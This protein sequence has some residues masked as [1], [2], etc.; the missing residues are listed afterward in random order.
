MRFLHLFICGLIGAS[1]VLA[2]AKDTKAKTVTIPPLS[3]SVVSA[4]AKEKDVEKGLKAVL[5]DQSTDLF[6][7]LVGGVEK[8]MTT[9][10]DAE[11]LGAIQSKVATIQSLYTL[12]MQFSEGN[13]T[14]A[15][16]TIADS[17]IGSLN[18]PAATAVWETVKATRESYIAVAATKAALNI[19]TLYSVVN[20]DRMIVGESSGGAPPTINVDS[21]TVDYFFNKYLITNSSVRGM[22]R[23]YV[24]KV[25]HQDWPE[26]SWSNYMSG[27]M[28]IGSGIDTDEE[29]DLRQL[30]G[31]FKNVARGWIRSLLND[32]NKQVLLE[33]QKTRLRQEM[34]EY[35]KYATKIANYN[36][37]NFPAT[38]K[39]LL[40]IKNA[41][42]NISVYNN[43]LNEASKNN[44]NALSALSKASKPRA[45]KIAFETWK[46]VLYQQ[47]IT[48]DNYAGDAFYLR[49]EKLHKNLKSAEA[50]TLSVMKKL[51]DSM[52]GFYDGRAHV[53]EEDMQELKEQNR[54]E[55]VTEYDRMLKGDYIVSKYMRPLIIPPS[56]FTS[57]MKGGDSVLNEIVSLLNKG[58]YSAAYKMQYEKLG[59]S[60][61]GHFYS[62]VY[63]DDALAAKIKSQRAGHEAKGNFYNLSE[64]EHVS[65]KNIWKPLYEE[66]KASMEDLMECDSKPIALKGAPNLES[67]AGEDAQLGY[68]KAMEAYQTSYRF[69]EAREADVE[70]TKNNSFRPAPI[71][72]TYEEYYNR[73]IINLEGTWKASC[74]AGIGEMGSVYQGVIGK[75]NA[76]SMKSYALTQA[77][78]KMT[79]G[80]KVKYLR[81]IG[82]SAQINKLTAPTKR[83]KS[84]DTGGKL[85][86]AQ[87]ELT[88]WC[89][90]LPK[91]EGSSLYG[92]GRFLTDP[93]VVYKIQGGY[94]DSTLNKMKTDMDI[95]IKDHRHAVDLWNEYEQI[96][97]EDMSIIEVMVRPFVYE[98]FSVSGK[99]ISQIIKGTNDRIKA[100]NGFISAMPG[101]MD[102]FIQKTRM[103]HNNCANAKAQML[104]VGKDLKKWEG[105]ALKDKILKVYEGKLV[106]A[107]IDV[108]EEGLF[109]T[110]KPYRHYLTRNELKNY[111][112]TRALRPPASYSLS[113]LNKHYPNVFKEYK[114]ITDMSGY[115][116][117]RS[118]NIIVGSSVIYLDD[119]IVV[120][121]LLNKADV[122]KDSFDR[123]I[124]KISETFPDLLRPMTGAG[125]YAVFP[126]SPKG[127]EAELNSSVGKRYVRLATTIKRALS[128][129]SDAIAR[130]MTEEQEAANKERQKRGAGAFT[131]I[132]ESSYWVIDPRYNTNAFSLGLSQMTITQENLKDGKIIITGRLNSLE[133]V[134]K[135]LVSTDKRS[136][137]EMP[138]SKDIHFSFT[139]IEN[140]EYNVVVKL[141]RDEGFK[142]LLLSLSEKA[143]IKYT[144]VD[145]N[146][147]IAGAIKHIAESYEQQN[148]PAFTNFISQDYLGNKSS[149]EE[150][151]RFDFEMFTSIGLK[152]YINRVTKS[153]EGQWAVNL[154]WDKTQIPRSRGTQQRTSGQTVITLVNEEGVLKIRNLRGNLLYA[155][156]S[157]DIAAASGLGTSRVDSIRSA[158]DSR[159]PDQPGAST[160]SDSSSSSSSSS[161]LISVQNV[162]KDYMAHHYFD[163]DNGSWS[164][165]GSAGGSDMMF[166]GTYGPIAEAGTATYVKIVGT[167]FNDVSTAPDGGYAAIWPAATAGE[168]YAFKTGAGLYGKFKLD[169]STDISGGGGTNRVVF[170][171][172]I[173]TD[174]SKNVVTQ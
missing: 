161:S 150:G 15:A 75:V 51:Y 43:Y 148:L 90:G 146:K 97:D 102:K 52:E 96:S 100:V 87:G 126:P 27:M 152:L 71:K 83:M 163:F 11:I 73:N 49:D 101:D 39:I 104:K 44:S 53:D 142:P 30:Q 124:E 144:K 162:T 22:V 45:K 32:L 127:M 63:F 2:I 95:R 10:D 67:I 156:L 70:Y 170:R 89:K 173:Q 76:I 137:Q 99:S 136:W 19:E 59:V 23:S 130:K 68:A 147:R 113:F 50:K 25:L 74:R 26:Q 169:S 160:T 8:A 7:E 109:K 166:E 140:T 129:R 35:A 168:V 86:Y 69:W 82:L 16:L 12:G 143:T 121:Q 157:P 111:S 14:D 158:R 108:D 107:D 62:Y 47:Q 56:S 3:F 131:S 64:H 57:K 28:A 94:D 171:Y 29:A 110:S 66:M 119:I 78:K 41:T 88:G 84:R 123:L 9:A 105:K 4:L 151:V 120:E 80:A 172:S 117:A 154:K 93:T 155:T 60:A 79:E 114:A 115:K 48:L 165:P 77:Y 159:T 81:L 17:A 58:D 42:K 174:G 133:N 33:Y 132:D 31:E 85:L 1:L 13:Y 20:R 46:P 145:N 91:A 141:I 139:P 153:S 37:A 106:L 24:E 5:K 116:A 72:P 55:P 36:T 138:F 98:D 54:K 92:F 122:T 135:L 34:A 125:V 103:E 40:K 167:A 21:K 65:K 118:D 164:T 6:F 149:L 61:R 18:N 38:W 128:D 134:K 112:Q